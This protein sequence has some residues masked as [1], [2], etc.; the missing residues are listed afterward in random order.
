MLDPVGMCPVEPV[1]PVEPYPM[2]RSQKGKGL[3]VGA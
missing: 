3:D 2:S 1:V